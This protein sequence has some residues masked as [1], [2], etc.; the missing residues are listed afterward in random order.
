M[1]TTAPDTYALISVANGK[2]HKPAGPIPR[3]QVFRPILTVCGRTVTPLN[4]YKTTNDANS[5]TGGRLPRHLCQHCSRRAVPSRRRRPKRTGFDC[6]R[7]TPW[8]KRRR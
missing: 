5:Y 1:D 7:A 2:Y 3:S 6:H 4:Y 8:T